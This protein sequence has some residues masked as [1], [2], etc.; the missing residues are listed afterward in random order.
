M[1]S[2]TISPVPAI[3]QA[4]ALFEPVRRPE[5]MHVE[6]G[7]LDLLGDEDPTGAHPGQRLMLSSGLAHIY[8]RWWRP[9]G[10]RVLMGVMGPGTRD[11]HRI[12]LDMLAV[13]P[14][15][16]VLDVAC[17]PGNFT[18]DFA[19]A[20]GDE[21]LV[22]GIDASQTMLARAVASNGSANT[23]Y[24]RG[25][26]CALPFRDGSFDAICCFAALYLIE[27][28][29]HALEEI[30]RVLAPGGRVA[31]LSSCN[32]GPLP[33]A[34]TNAI[35]RSLSGVRV[36]GREELTGALRDHGLTSIEQRVAGLA[37]FVSARKRE[38]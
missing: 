11:E 13:A 21:G 10:G 4:L 31:L 5:V 2:T 29:M 28:P 16:C 20:A 18:H 32:R 7:Y 33:A 37:Q 34:T 3:E 24:V 23:A 6:N 19:S 12:A 14:G 17:G 36:F 35:V 38:D 26:A 30:V 15:E 1:S 25:D 27:R 22:V 9:V 8:E